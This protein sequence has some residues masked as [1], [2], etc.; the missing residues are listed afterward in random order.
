MLSYNRRQFLR[1]TGIS[2]LAAVAAHAAVKGVSILTNP[3]DPI[4][5]S[6]PVQW[7]AKELEQSLSSVGV[8]VQRCANISEVAAGN[9]CILLAGSSTDAARRILKAAGIAV[10][11]SVES[12]GI[13]PGTLSGKPLLLA[14][15]YDVRGLV[16]AV[17]DLVDRVQNSPDPGK[18]I[19]KPE[20]VRRAARQQNSQHYP[21]VYKRRGRQ[22]LV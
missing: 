7:A 21:P 19:A 9:H 4:A 5:L 22:G 11:E 10:S 20:S 3:A 8:T 14:A 16:F 1:V 15:G 18:R 17:L 12:L 2:S 13:A 6:G